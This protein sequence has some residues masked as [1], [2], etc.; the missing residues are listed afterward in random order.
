[1]GDNELNLQPV[2]F[3]SL[4]AM[5]FGT[6][7]YLCLKGTVKSEWVCY[8]ALG[9]GDF[10]GYIHCSVI[11]ALSTQSTGNIQLNL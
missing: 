2:T 11:F 7:W 8:L 4:F 10:C 3:L 6:K 1:M 5:H 9:I